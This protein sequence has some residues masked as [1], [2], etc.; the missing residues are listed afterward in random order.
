MYIKYGTFQF[1]PWEASLAN[2]SI[3]AHYTPRK[4]KKS[5]LVE[6]TVI[7]TVVASGQ[8]SVGTRLSQ[9]QTALLE[10]GL[11]FGLYHDDN[12]PTVHYIQSSHP[13]N[14]TGNQVSR[15]IFPADTGAEYI[16]GREF[17]FTI[18]AEIADFE[19]SL[20]EYRDSYAATGDCGPIYEW[21]ATREG[22]LVRQTAPASMQSVI[23][24][25][26]AVTSSAFF[27]PPAPYYA[28]PFHLSH[29]KEIKYTGPQRYPQSA[30]GYVTEWKYHYILPTDTFNLPTIR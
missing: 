12:T 24:S 26:Y 6:M 19:T 4:F 16:T 13:N 22:L 5:Q 25:G 21:E 27:T 10:D 29:L 17:S 20:I 3:Q 11:D 30:L 9:I 8:Y 1:E 2:V 14:L 28:P 7:G 18:S 23:H 15:K